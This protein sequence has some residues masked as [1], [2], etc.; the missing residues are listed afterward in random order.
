MAYP[1]EGYK[2]SNYGVK[3]Y[4]A[5]QVKEQWKK[6]VDRE[7]KVS[8]SYTSIMSV[9]KTLA[10]GASTAHNYKERSRKD[11]LYREF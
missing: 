11:G 2:M 10:L 8:E 9:I 3:K 6:S 1:G 7:K 4:T 5:E